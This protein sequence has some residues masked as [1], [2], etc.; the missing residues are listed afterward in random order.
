MK[1]TAWGKAEHT[2]GEEYEDTQG[3]GDHLQA[4]MEA[5]TSPSLAALSRDQLCRHPDLEHLASRTVKR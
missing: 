2:Y 4:T 5:W 3:E 1:R